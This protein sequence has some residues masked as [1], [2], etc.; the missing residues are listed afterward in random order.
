MYLYE[1]A[2]GVIASLLVESRLRG[3]R[4]AHRVG[5]PAKNRPHPAGRHDDRVGRKCANFHRAQIHGADPAADAL[6]VKHRRKKF[7][8]L[9]LLDLAFGL[10]TPHLLIKGVKKLLAG[11]GSGKSSAMV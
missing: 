1:F 4:A 10:V 5:A 2:V 11:G 7:P 9:V 6:R 8:R 3:T